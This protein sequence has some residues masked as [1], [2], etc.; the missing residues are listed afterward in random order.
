MDEIVKE[1]LS[2]I[3]RANIGFMPHPLVDKKKE[4]N[5]ELVFIQS[6]DLIIEKQFGK[7]EDCYL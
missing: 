3:R 6:N 1:P 7:R 4:C 2:V 5:K